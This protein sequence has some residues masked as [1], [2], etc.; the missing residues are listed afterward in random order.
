M[1]A[2]DERTIESI[3]RPGVYDNIPEAVYHRDPV[4]GGSLSSSGARKLLAPSCP[5]LFR[6]EQTHPQPHKK[7]FDL[8]SAAHELVLGEGPGICSR[9]RRHA[10]QGR[11]GQRDAPEEGKSLLPNSSGCRRWR[12]AQ[13]APIAGACFRPGTGRAVL[14]WKDPDTGVIC[15]ARLDCPHR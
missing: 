11:E 2:T 1:T 7:T 8:G 4:P 9:R 6:H 15:R 3:T 10:H 5:A 13:A 12:N 14:F